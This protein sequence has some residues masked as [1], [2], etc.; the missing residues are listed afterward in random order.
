MR[1]MRL[2]NE[3]AGRD[4]LLGV[5]VPEDTVRLLP[6]LGISSI[7]NLLAAVKTARWFDL[8]DRDV[9]FTS[10][11]DS[12]CLYGTRLEE[13]RIEHGDYDAVT[14]AVD[15]ERRLLGATTDHTRELTYPDRKAIHNLKYFT[16]V[17]QQ[18]RTAEDLDELWDPDFWSHLQAQLP[19]W[20]DAICDFN[21][22]TGVLTRLRER[23][24]SVA[25]E[26]GAAEEPSG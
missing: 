22:E 1:L 20:D 18:G 23:A 15:Y 13:M 25:A 17:E 10:F 16:W 8:D 4:F 11:T 2:F 14:A 6:L 21:A 24:A 9:L 7:G 19:A 3:P 5:G 26:A 12:I